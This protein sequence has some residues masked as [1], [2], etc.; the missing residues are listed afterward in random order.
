MGSSFDEQH[1][2]E[3]R[4]DR[5]LE[6]EGLGRYA[7]YRRQVIAPRQPSVTVRQ[8]NV[9]LRE[10]RITLIPKAAGVLHPCA[11]DLVEYVGV[12]GRITHKVC[13]RCRADLGPVGG[14][15]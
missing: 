11:H 8:P 4:L 3:E 13:A 12:R 1:D 14:S 7:P 2:L 15:K 9:T 5:D 6:H 10:P